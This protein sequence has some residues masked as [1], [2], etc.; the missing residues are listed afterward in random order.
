MMMSL[1]VPGILKEPNVAKAEGNR[2]ADGSQVGQRLGH[3]QNGK[4]GREGGT[5]KW[6]KTRKVVEPKNRK[7]NQRKQQQQQKQRRNV[8]REEA[9]DTW[10]GQGKEREAVRTGRGASKEELCVAYVKALQCRAASLEG[11]RG[12]ANTNICMRLQPAGRLTDKST[13][14][15]SSCLTNIGRRM[16]FSTTFH[17]VSEQK[18]QAQMG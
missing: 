12:S 11:G 7:R 14:L 15:E 5:N 16:L 2:T 13:Q 17:R 3:F 1:P 4:M 8:W 18:P 9:E 6:R 10:L